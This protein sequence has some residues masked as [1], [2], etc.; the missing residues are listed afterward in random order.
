MVAV[1]LNA[2]LAEGERLTPLDLTILDMVTSASLACGFHAGNR[3]VMRAAAAACLDRGVTIGAHVSYRDRTGFGRRPVHPPAGVL[4]ADII[5]QCEVLSGEV[6]AAGGEVSYVK[7]HGAL[8]NQ[9]GVDAAVAASVVEAIALQGIGV[10]VA[11]AG[12]VVA[13][14]AREAG[15][16][17][18]PEGFPDRGYRSDGHLQ[19]RGEPGAVI[20]D[21]AVAGRRAVSLVNGG[22]VDAIDG[23]WTAIEA[24][25]LCIHGDAPD[26]GDIA[27]GVR[28][29]L[30]AEGITVRPFVPSHRCREPG[31]PMP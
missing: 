12:T 29:A 31:G 21:P 7:P 11:Q 3:A 26:A 23:T 22:G 19:D 2:D 13:D 17:V 9:M 8:Y 28:S 6:D 24:E 20:A 10:L 14:R 15:L 30:T 16:R 4:V 1:D 18:V 27:R 5:E 25:T